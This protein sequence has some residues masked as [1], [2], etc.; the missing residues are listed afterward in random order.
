M[1]RWV[2]A[3]SPILI[4]ILDLLFKYVI[5]QKKRV[6]LFGHDFEYHGKQAIRLGHL[7]SIVAKTILDT[8]NADQDFWTSN[9]PCLL[10]GCVEIA[11]DNNELDDWVNLLKNSGSLSS[12]RISIPSSSRPLPR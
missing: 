9:M 4:I 10:L 11:K 12:V 8:P 3:E 5:E 2:A 7:F 6:L 1:T